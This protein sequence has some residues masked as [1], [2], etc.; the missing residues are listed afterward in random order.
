MIDPKIQEIIAATAQATAK[1]TAEATVRELQGMMTDDAA[2]EKA[3]KKAEKQLWEYKQLK[4]STELKSQR[5]V[6]EIDACLATAANE[7]YIDVIR[8]FYFDHIKNAACAKIMNC[9]ERN[10]R[11]ARKALVKRFF[12]PRLAAGDFIRELLL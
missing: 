12:V 5:L 6:A 4:E 3:I 8:L 11:K 1:S 10:L 7:P 9:D 2:K